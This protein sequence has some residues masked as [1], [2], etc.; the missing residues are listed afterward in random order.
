MSTGSNAALS[1]GLGGA[2]GAVGAGLAPV[3][4]GLSLAIPLISAGV[5]GLFSLFS[6]HQQANAT[7]DAAKLQADAS[8]AA[9]AEQKRIFDLQRADRQPYVNASLGALG[10]AQ[11]LA[12]QSHYMPLPAQQLGATSPVAQTPSPMAIGSL[13][14]LGQSAAPAPSQGS[15][16]P[17][18]VFRAPDG[19]MRRMP[20]SLEPELA[21]KRVVRIQ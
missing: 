17:M 14:Q 9:L 21:A 12:A 16:E 8:A 1:T 18:G 5:S 15:G 7:K 11:N 6:G 10:Q 19:S 3:T 13:G 4:G 2:A 20:L